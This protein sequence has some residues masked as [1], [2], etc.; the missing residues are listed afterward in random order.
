MT[1]YPVKDKVVQSEFVL[2]LKDKS[3]NSLA[4]LVSFGIDAFDRI[5][6]AEKQAQAK[7][8]AGAAADSVATMDSAGV[9]MAPPPAP[10]VKKHK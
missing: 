8:A 3:K 5:S 4:A 2:N 10:P 1:Q 6:A 7:W 9:S